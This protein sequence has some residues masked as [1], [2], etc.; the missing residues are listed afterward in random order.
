MLIVEVVGE[1]AARAHPHDAQTAILL[2]ILVDL[3][4]VVGLLHLAVVSLGFYQ[5]IISGLAQTS[6]IIGGQALQVEQSNV[7]PRNVSKLAKAFGA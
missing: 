1:M 2:Q 6:I 3:L 5:T 4:L 7:W